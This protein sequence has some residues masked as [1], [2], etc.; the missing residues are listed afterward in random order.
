MPALF[1]PLLLIFAA[2]LPAVVLSAPNP[3]Q[4]DRSIVWVASPS[5][6]NKVQTG[7]GFVVN[8]DGYV[9]TNNHVIQG[10]KK[11]LV[12]H[13]SGSENRK[14]EAQLVWR[15]E[16]YD[17]AILKVPGLNKP[18]L[19]LNLHKPRKTDKVSA[20]GF[21]GAAGDF[22]HDKLDNMLET[23]WTQGIVSRTLESSWVKN[24]PEFTIVQHS[25]DINGGN[26]G[27][28]LLDDCGRVL[29]VNTMAS[30]TKLEIVTQAGTK[31]VAVG[32]SARGIFYASHASAFAAA[33]KENNIPYRSGGCGMDFDDDDEGWDIQPMPT[34]DGFSRPQESE[35][36]MQD[37]GDRG[38]SNANW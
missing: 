37:S 3:E 25:A 6:K 17:L 26:S 31:P 4:V 7:T 14:Q 18:A 12:L 32:K 5:A 10:A 22:N 38:W 8:R 13:K 34:V 21:P 11:I 30:V 15:S 35:R 20:A 28:P 1:I 9:V 27:G 29:G 24:G 2:L 33:L 36:D 23:T 19:K 16:G